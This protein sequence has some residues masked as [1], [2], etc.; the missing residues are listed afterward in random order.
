M[1][2]LPAFFSVLLAA[3][4]YAATEAPAVAAC[5]TGHVRTLN[6][7]A[8]NIF[9]TMISP[10]RDHV[11]VFA[12]VSPLLDDLMPPKNVTHPKYESERGAPKK[13]QTPHANSLEIKRWFSIF[14][15]IHLEVAASAGQN[16]GLYSCLLLV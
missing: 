4:Q 5:I 7:T 11:D 12:A 2:A 6:V 3:E 10:I 9:E 15:P 16:S 13:G 14:S 1:L 8:R